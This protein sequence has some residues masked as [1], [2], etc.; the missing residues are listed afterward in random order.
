MA[1]CSQPA[2]DWAIQDV[3]C[4]SSSAVSRAGLALSA[5]SRQHGTSASAEHQPKGSHELRSKT[6]VIFKP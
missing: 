3:S 4:A 5:P 2:P 1:P 6:T